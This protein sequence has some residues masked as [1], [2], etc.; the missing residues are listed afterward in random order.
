M[1]KPRLVVTLGDPGG[2]GPEVVAKALTA[3]H[4]RRAADILLLGDMRLL[5]RATR[6]RDSVSALDLI[7]VDEP[8]FVKGIAVYNPVPYRGRL[9]KPGKWTRT[10]GRL[11]LAW[12]EEGIR[13]CREGLADALVTGPVC[14]AAWKAAGSR[15][16]GHTELLAARC[17]TKRAVMML[18]G[19]GLRVALTTVHIPLR[20]VVRKLTC[21]RLVETG[22][23]LDADLR[24]HFRLDEPRIAVLGLNP[25]AGE[26]GNIGT[27][28][29]RLVAPAIQ[30]LRRRKIDAVGPVPAD[31]AFH[32][33]RQGRYDA[34]LAMYHDQGLAPLKTLAFDT[35]VNVTLGLPIIR[36]SV[37]HGTAFDLVGSGRANEASCVAA[38]ELAIDMVRSE[39]AASR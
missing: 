4:V 24:R 2:I 39:K 22:A 31:T 13:L 29:A 9:P 32:Q 18:T 3:P 37:D 5:H 19:G 15:Y 27:E 23:I 34:V 35:G 6:K 12:V 14:K 26:E 20:Q 38:L 33:A 8:V 11:S 25:H 10:T 36:T 21:E 1:A 17:R 16:P 28:E 30:R 7:R